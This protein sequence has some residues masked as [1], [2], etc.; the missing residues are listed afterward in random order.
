MKAS[1]VV[2]VYNEAAT[3]EEVVRLLLALPMDR[4]VLLVDDGSRDGSA[5]ILDR[6]AAV[7]AGTVRVIRLPRNRGKGAA[8]RAGIAAAQGDVIVVQDADMELDP[9]QIVDLV[10]PIARGETEVV[11]GSRFLDG[12]RRGSWLQYGANRFLSALTNLLFGLGITDMET[13]Y[14]AFRRDL[15]G[16]MRLTAERFEIEPE[17]TA[18]IARL[19]RRILEVPVRYRPRTRAEGKKIRGWDGAKAVGML[20]GKWWEMEDR[21]PGRGW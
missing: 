7:H 20:L 6:L 2:P 1:I 5:A 16:Q 4:E 11:Y 13:C 18:E 8:V 17:L 15:A 21:G 19:G 10:R 12:V 3:V 9:G 14:K